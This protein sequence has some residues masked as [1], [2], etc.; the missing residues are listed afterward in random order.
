MGTG[1]VE[2][3]TR[4]GWGIIHIPLIFGTR[5]GYQSKLDGYCS[6]CIEDE[7]AQVWWG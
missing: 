4:R 6:S 3:Q 2:V 5:D 7:D 1:R